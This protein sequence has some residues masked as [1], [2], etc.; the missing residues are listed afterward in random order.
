M[1]ILQ[2]G[3]HFEVIFTFNL[4][5]LR[6]SSGGASRGVLL[7][8]RY[9][10]DIVELL[11]PAPEVQPIC[12]LPYMIFHPELS[13]KSSAELPSTCKVEGFPRQ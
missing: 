3:L 10:E 11:D 6:R 12:C 2:Q 7:Q 5:R 1:S 9:K 4:D 13:Y 8:L